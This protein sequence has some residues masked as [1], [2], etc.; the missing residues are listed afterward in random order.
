MEASV[1]R[2]G[3]E[4]NA[5][6][7]CGGTR[8][9][10]LPA[11]FVPL[12][13]HNYLFFMKTRFSLLSIL[14]IAVSIISFV[15]CIVRNTVNDPHF[16]EKGYLIIDSSDSIVPQVGVESVKFF[17]EESGSMNGFFRRSVPNR[18]KKDVWEICSYFSRVAPNMTILTNNGTIG[19]TIPMKNFQ[20][21]MNT[22]SCISAASTKV[23]VMIESILSSI[24]TDKGEVAVLISDM[25]YSPVGQAAPAVLLSQY[26]TDLSYIFGK[27][28][29]ALCL[30]C[31][32]SE[33]MNNI[34]KSICDNSPYDY[35]IIGNERQVAIIRDC[36]STHLT[37]AG[38]FVDNI[39]S[40]FDYG[41]IKYSFGRPNRCSQFEDQPTFEQ[42]EEADESDTCKI[43]LNVDIAPYRWILTD[44][45]T[46]RDSFKA[47]ALYGSQ[48]EIGKI[49]I[50]VQNVTNRI[51]K[52][53]ATAMVELKLVNM[54]TDSEVIEWA[55]DL[56][57]TQVDRFQPFFNALNEGDVTKSYSIEDFIHGMF[58]GGVVNKELEPN[59]IL[60]TKKG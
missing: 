7:L 36:I 42:Y 5:K 21:R 20:T 3:T 11:F 58:Y 18:F 8:T 24:D 51:L 14:I 15:S 29:K 48:V 9:D 13:N 40:G 10:G 30:V 55:L 60:V 35:F 31:A 46:F 39:E 47:N 32:T 25:K 56:P 33:Y 44:E 22:G 45:N 1:A 16:D 43:R 17:I 2:S 53:T 34:G 6:A 37:N 27:Y 50:E 26:S 19:S 38:S 12:V 23:P 4:G 41:K 52:R 59:Y 57:D 28:N 49:N 54:A